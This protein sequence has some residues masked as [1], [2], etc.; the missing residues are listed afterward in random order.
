MA[1]NIP[2]KDSAL[3]VIASKRAAQE[4]GTRS[5]DPKITK[6][7]TT[8]PEMGTTTTR[9]S[10]SGSSSSAKPASRSTTKAAPAKASTAKREPVRAASSVSAA[11]TKA[12][13]STSG[14]REITTFSAPKA[15][16]VVTQKITAPTIDNSKK[17]VASTTKEKRIEKQVSTYNKEKKAG[18]SFDTYQTRRTSETQAAIKK[19][20]AKK[21]KW[22]GVGGDNSSKRK[23]GACLTC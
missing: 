10:W 19:G 12:S 14:S 21:E 13:S 11:P 2:M 9:T 17:F 5:I 1:N 18:E 6:T 20:P 22:S 15:A 8:N 7:T 23:S 3:N 16:G 4:A